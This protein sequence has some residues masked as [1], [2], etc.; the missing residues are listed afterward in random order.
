M[1]GMSVLY[2]DPWKVATVGACAILAVT[3][4]AGWWLGRHAGVGSVAAAV[5]SE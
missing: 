2:A 5:R 4:G 1:L 3:S